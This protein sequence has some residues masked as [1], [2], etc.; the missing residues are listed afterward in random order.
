MASVGVPIR[1][2]GDDDPAVTTIDESG[3]LILGFQDQSSHEIW[4]FRVLSRCLT[5]RSEYFST[6]LDPLK[7]K[8]GAIVSETHKTLRGQYSSFSLASNRELPHIVVSGMEHTPLDHLTREIFADY[9][10]ILHGQGGEADLKLP[11]KGKPTAYLVTLAI[12]ADRF[13]CL[14]VVGPYLKAQRLFVA[15]DLRRIQK[16]PLNEE[17]LRQKLLICI[18]LDYPEYVAFFSKEIIFQGSTR[19]TSDEISSAENLPLWWDLPKGLE[20]ELLYRRESLLDTVNSLQKHFLN[21]YTSKDRQCKLGYDSS[22]QCDSF[23]LGEMIRFFTRVGT[24]RLQG[25][26]FDTQGPQYY[27]G[28]IKTLL[29][30]LRQCPSYQINPNHAHCGLRTRIEPVLNVLENTPGLRVRQIK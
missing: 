9:L 22:P 1:D 18:L 3:D 25:T 4:L 8:E 17:L 15:P 2:D 27:P 24:L 30:T 6:L 16:G 19:W 14:R 28:D 11:S 5:Y 20:A 26:I 29:K 7:F 12:I 21:L 13:D 23:Q 10:R